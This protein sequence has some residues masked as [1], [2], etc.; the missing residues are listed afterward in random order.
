MNIQASY[1]PAAPSFGLM[2]PARGP[3]GADTVV[4]RHLK[5]RSEIETVLHLRDEIDL[6]AH[7]SA[8]SNFVAIEKKETSVV[9]CSRS[10]WTGSS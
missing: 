10:T 3:V 4:L 9:L 2:N 7:N 8:S 1:S 6:S 5:S